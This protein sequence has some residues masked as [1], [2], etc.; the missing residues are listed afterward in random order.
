MR[1]NL[2]KYLEEF[3]YPENYKEVFLPAMDKLLESQE[4]KEA[5]L[6]HIEDYKSENLNWD[7][8]V[9]DAVKYAPTIGIHEHTIKNLNL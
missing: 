3:E 2:V 4:A 5:L 6:G 8:I 1:E 7:S 9:S